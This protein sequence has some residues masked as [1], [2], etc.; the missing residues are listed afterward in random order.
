MSW[1]QKDLL[2]AV[3]SIEVRS[4]SLIWFSRFLNISLLF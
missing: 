1:S 4:Y 2:M 3:S